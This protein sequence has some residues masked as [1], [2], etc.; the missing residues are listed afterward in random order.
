MTHEQFQEQMTRIT[1]RFGSKNYP[2]DICFKIFSEC[3]DLSPEWFGAMVTRFLTSK[4]T[5]PLAIEFTHSAHAE[6][7]R[8]S[9]FT[10]TMGDDGYE[11]IFSHEERLNMLRFVKDVSVGKIPKD[12]A[13]EFARSVQKIIDIKSRIKCELCEN[14]VVFVWEQSTQSK[15]CF[16]CHCKLGMNRQETWPVWSAQ[17]RARFIPEADKFRQELEPEGPEAS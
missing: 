4:R 13:L 8:I 3:R 10:K 17:L 14:G 9:E 12:K 16:R 5:A 1:D 2:D 6:K 7:R 15:F 11:S